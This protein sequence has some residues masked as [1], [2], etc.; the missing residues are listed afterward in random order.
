MSTDNTIQVPV[1]EDY[2]ET[3]AAVTQVRDFVEG[4][5]R[6]KRK[7][8]VYLKHPSQVDKTSSAALA[9]YDDYIANAEVD[10]DTDDTRRE[11][12]GKMRIDDTEIEVP[13]KLNYLLENADNDGTTLVN[14]IQCAVNNILQVKYHAIVADY[15]G[16]SGVDLE[17]ISISDAKALNPRAT[18]K[19]YSR[20]NIV[21]WNFT[22]I[23]GAMRLS[24][25]MLLERGYDFEQS[26][27]LQTE[28]QS[29][30]ILALDENGDYYQQKMVRGGKGDGELGE[31]DY[32]LVGGKPLKFIPVQFAADEEL[33]PDSLPRQLGYLYS[34]SEKVLQRYRKSATYSE[35]QKALLP[36]TYTKGWRQGDDDLFQEL[37]DRSNIESGP[38]SVNAL[39]NEVEVSVES[40][41]NSMEDFH[42]Y[43]DQSRKQVSEMGGKSGA[44]AGNMTATEAD[45][46]ATSQ[47]ALLNTIATSV[48]DAYIKLISYCAMFEG[49]VS[50]EE[51]DSY[52]QV[53]VTM[54]R[55]FATPRMSEEEV[56]RLIA[57]KTMGLFTSEQVIKALAEGGRLTD[58]VEEH[59]AA[60][61]S[62]G[63][64]L[65]LPPV[66]VS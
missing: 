1:H 50:P 20:E 43:F 23:N 4:A 38:Y 61:E 51:V 18:L 35:V 28:V 33:E 10:S 45:I 21:N 56:D 6:V 30:L 55:D 41:Q 44:Q 40:A 42:W 53:M 54:P 64:S 34:I 62:D 15:Q 13:D 37:N 59:M 5:N 32:M 27:Y 9:R 7:K 60:L 3:M 8:T 36:T 63:G 16:L 24:F 65:N 46:V 52:D 39:P 48:E 57:L 22:R 11:L 31:R 19:Q 26:S 14:S 17:S 66:E 58:S 49:L 12:L 2:R 47:N 25:L 29:Y